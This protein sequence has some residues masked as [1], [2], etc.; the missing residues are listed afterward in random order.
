MY[1]RVRHVL[2]ENKLHRATVVKGAASQSL[3]DHYV[4]TLPTPAIRYQQPGRAAHRLLA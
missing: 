2:Y 3:I 1:C 4:P